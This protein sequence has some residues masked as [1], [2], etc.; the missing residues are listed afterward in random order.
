MDKILASFQLSHPTASKNQIKRKILDIAEKER[1][2]SGHGSQRWIV[3]EEAK[4]KAGIVLPDAAFTPKRVK[5]S[6]TVCT[7]SSSSTTTATATSSSSRVFPVRAAAISMASPSSR[8]RIPASGVPSSRSVL[9]A[10]PSLPLSPSPTPSSSKQL[11]SESSPTVSIDDDGVIVDGVVACEKTAMKYDMDGNDVAALDGPSGSAT[12]PA[13][14]IP[15]TTPRPPISS[16]SS[17]SGSNCSSGAPKKVTTSLLNFFN[18]PTPFTDSIENVVKKVNKE[19]SEEG[20]RE[21]TEEKEKAYLIINVDDS[22]S[23]L[24]HTVTPAA[25]VTAVKGQFHSH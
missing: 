16:S 1:H 8:S 15:F 23:G 6:G 14:K 12:S 19:K 9:A 24:G 13:R 22:C 7:P 10:S 21:E 17:S 5:K 3:K 20:A 18:K 11:A 4:S 25:A 2:P